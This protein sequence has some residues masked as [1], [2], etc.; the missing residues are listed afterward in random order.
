M[1]WVCCSIRLSQMAALLQQLGCFKDMSLEDRTSCI[2]SL[3]ETMQ[4]IAPLE[5]LPRAAPHIS[6]QGA[7]MQSGPNG[8]PAMSTS[9]GASQQSQ[10]AQDP[11]IGLA[12]RPALSI[13]ELISK[14]GPPEFFIFDFSSII[15]GMSTVHPITKYHG[16]ACMLV[17]SNSSS[18]SEHELPSQACRQTS[19]H[20]RHQCALR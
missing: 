7:A 1:S 19:H 20:C 9:T 16:L 3:C 18:E 12:G 14:H 15:V 2:R 17:H 4:Q 10:A 13:A 11:H 6:G 5:R 8:S